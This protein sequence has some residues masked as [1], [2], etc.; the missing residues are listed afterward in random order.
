M[1]LTTAIQEAI[2]RPLSIVNQGEYILKA[3]GYRP[4]LVQWQPDR[5]PIHSKK[6]PGRW[7]RTKP[8]SRS[9]GVLQIVRHHPGFNA[10]SWATVSD[11]IKVDSV[12]EDAHAVDLGQA[13]TAL[14]VR[15]PLADPQIVGAMALVE[16]AQA[17]GHLDHG[18]AKHPA[19]PRILDRSSRQLRVRSVGKSIVRASPTAPLFS[20]SS[21]SRSPSNGRA[22]A[23]SFVSPA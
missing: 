13:L 21:R 9:A 18:L 22:L 23:A 11:D 19:Q 5:S 8:G 4:R 20:V 3:G 7:V 6:A 15:K 10:G 14:V 1:E 2:E 16:E 12:I 17:L